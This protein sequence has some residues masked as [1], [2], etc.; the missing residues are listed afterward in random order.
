MVI[1]K[2]T[3]CYTVTIQNSWFQITTTSQQYQI[4]IRTNILSS[5]IDQLYGFKMFNV[6]GAE[7]TSTTKQVNCHQV[8]REENDLN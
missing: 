3:K 2:A 5:F 7:L 6:K 1:G 4:L 8:N